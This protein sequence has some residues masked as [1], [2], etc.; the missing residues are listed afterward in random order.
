MIG[1]DGVAHLSNGIFKSLHHLPCGFPFS[2][3]N[4]LQL[5]ETL[6]IS[7]WKFEFLNKFPLNFIYCRIL[8]QS[9][10]L[11]E[12]PNGSLAE[13]GLKLNEFGRI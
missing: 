8:L 13:R 11:D 3:L 10:T 2:L 4:I 6:L 7:Q 5:R 12:P 9:G 1:I